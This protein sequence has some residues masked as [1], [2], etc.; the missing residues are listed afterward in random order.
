M[1]AAGTNQP[2]ESLSQ[3]TVQRGYEMVRLDSHVQ[4]SAQHIHDIVGVNGGKN[5]V[6][7]QG[8]LN[9]DLSSFGIT[10]LAH[11]DLVRIVAQNR[12]KAAREC[13]SFLFIYRDLS[14]AR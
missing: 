12:A 6:A 1:L 14:Y 13:Q 3:H 11:H 7:C 8:G 9:G 5:E 4:K 2:N 10:N